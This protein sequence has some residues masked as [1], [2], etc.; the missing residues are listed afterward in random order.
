MKINRDRVIWELRVA[1]ILIAVSILLYFIHFAWFRDLP[2]ILIWSFT[3]LAFL[4]I[5]ALVMTLLINRIL[6][7]RDKALRLDKLNM[8]I[9]VFF[10]NV[11]NELLLHFSDWDAEDQ[12]LR[13]HFGAPKPWVNLHKKTALVILSK[14]HFS[15]T[16]TRDQ[17]IELKDFLDPRVD[18]LMRL[19]ENPNLLE[20]ETF[21]QLLRAVFHLAEELSYR[22]NLDSTPDADVRHLAG[23]IERVYRLIAREWVLYMIFLRHNFPFLFSLAVR[24]NPFDREAVATV[25]EKKRSPHKPDSNNGQ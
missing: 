7:A 17:L 20:H 22:N 16:V 23:D 4:P 13:N 11:G 25:S 1:A 10:S 8:L 6:S 14:H 2:H 18:F 24:T 21:T 9:G 3:S 12:Y 15:V 19:I 5:S